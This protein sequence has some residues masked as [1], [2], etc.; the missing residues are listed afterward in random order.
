MFLACRFL[1]ER[2]QSWM[3]GGLRAAAVIV[4][5]TSGQRKAA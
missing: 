1:S 4:Y 5:L 3:W 2:L